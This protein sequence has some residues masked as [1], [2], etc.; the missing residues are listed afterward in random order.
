MR[1]YSGILVMINGMNCFW[2]IIGGNRRRLKDKSII[3]GDREKLQIDRPST[4][5]RMSNLLEVIAVKIAKKR[6]G[7]YIDKRWR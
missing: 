3:E 2:Y 5:E 4:L 7:G 1:D 6:P